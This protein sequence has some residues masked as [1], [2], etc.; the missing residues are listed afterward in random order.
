M[1]ERDGTT[2]SADDTTAGEQDVATIGR[3]S[4]TEPPQFVRWVLGSGTAA[5]VGGGASLVGGIRALRRGDRATAF[6]RLLLGGVLA[7][8]AVGQR[9]SDGRRGVDQTDVVDTAPDVEG[10]GTETGGP[11]PATA[12]EAR[13][14]AGTSIDIEGTEA[15]T[16]DTS[17]D[18]EEAAE[19]AGA[20]EDVET[21]TA[22]GTVGAKGDAAEDEPTYEEPAAEEGATGEED[23]AAEEMAAEEEATAE[24]TA[25][26]AER[27]SASPEG[28]TF[29]R[30]GEAA[31]D[32]QSGRVPAPQEVFNLGIL[33]GG[34]EAFWGVREAD[35][36]VVVSGVF[37]PIEDVEGVDYV[38]S[39]EVNDDDRKVRVPDTVL[40]HWDDVADGGTAVV[41]GT[42]LVFVTSD[43]LREND[44]I[45]VVPVQ[46]SDELLE[47]S[48]E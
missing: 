16:D 1:S 13:E 29:E 41:S 6:P 38:A 4:V 15:D 30:L 10:V 2:E 45:L 44:Q 20:D 46:W 33:S 18:V 40:T 8:V 14:V 39:S 35:D 21:G 42:G 23:A 32:E 28:E 17:V 36:L 26:E 37:D 12:D 47:E 24:E 27:E 22:D 34:A 48:E 31:F 5:A 19:S 25:E 9:R 11:P 43:E 7:A 3:P